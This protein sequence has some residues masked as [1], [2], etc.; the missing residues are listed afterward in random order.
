MQPTAQNIEIQKLKSR[1]FKVITGHRN[2][3]INKSG[4]VICI[5]TGKLLKSQIRKQFVIID[6]KQMSVPKLIMLVFS[7][8]PYKINERVKFIDGDKTN[9]HITNVKY[10]RLFKDGEHEINKI[11]LML[12]IRCVFSVPKDYNVNNTL[13]T[14]SF[15]ETM[16]SASPL[17]S[18]SEAEKVVPPRANCIAFCLLT[19]SAI[20]R[21][22][23]KP[24][25]R[26]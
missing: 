14:K 12:A 13:L 7:K 9:F 11:D 24:G 17:S 20:L 6:G 23:P 25:I 3:Y 15:L 19:S 21:R 2:H 10:V 8:I 18:A 1:G 22:P 26:L 5:K 4:D 16:A